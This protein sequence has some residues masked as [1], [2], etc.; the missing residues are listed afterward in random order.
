MRTQ[1]KQESRCLKFIYQLW[2]TLLLSP[3]QQKKTEHCSRGT[4]LGA[5]IKYWTPNP[6]LLQMQINYCPTGASLEVLV[7]WQ[8]LRVNILLYC[9]LQQRR[10]CL[11]VAVIL[12]RLQVFCLCGPISQ[13]FIR[14]LFISYN[15]QYSVCLDY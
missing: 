15:K 12:E 13:I 14:W 9:K 11:T 6:Y 10:Y 1:T 3:T 5:E 7:S 8:M 2:C 4:V